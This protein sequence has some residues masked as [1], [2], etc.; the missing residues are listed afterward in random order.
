MSDIHEILESVATAA[1]SLD[2]IKWSKANGIS[3]HNISN[4]AELL[5][6]IY[7]EPWQPMPTSSTSHG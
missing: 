1:T 2:F 7:A 3:R 4:N 6:A 5:R